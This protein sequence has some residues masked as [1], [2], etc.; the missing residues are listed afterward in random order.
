MPFGE[1]G[2]FFVPNRLQGMESTDDRPE[3]AQDSAPN[4]CVLA[5]RQ[6]PI[7][8]ELGTRILFRGRLERWWR[9]SNPV[10]IALGSLIECRLKLTDPTLCGR[11]HFNHQS[12]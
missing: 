5:T 3:L 7:D 9:V 8:K 10:N 2:R 11:C 4:L 1:N 12:T 6:S